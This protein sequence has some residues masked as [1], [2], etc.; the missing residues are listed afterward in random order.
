MVW[1]SQGCQGLVESPQ[2]P[3]ESTAVG[4]LVKVASQLTTLVPC[5]YSY[6]IVLTSAAPVMHE[7]PSPAHCLPYK[8]L[9]SLPVLFFQFDI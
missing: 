1:R 7:R 6:C 4:L 2:C 9:F 5:V 3:Q 8:R